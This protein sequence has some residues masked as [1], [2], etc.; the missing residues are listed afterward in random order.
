MPSPACVGPV[1]TVLAGLQADFLAGGAALDD[2]SNRAVLITASTLGTGEASE[3][4][5][6]GAGV[7]VRVEANAARGAWRARPDFHAV[8][9]PLVPLRAGA[10]EAGL[11]G[12]QRELDRIGHQRGVFRR[13]ERD[14]GRTSR[15]H[16][17]GLNKAPIKCGLLC[18]ALGQ[19]P[20]DRDT[21]LVSRRTRSAH[22]VHL[23]TERDHRGP[24]RLGR[25]VPNRSNPSITFCRSATTSEGPAGLK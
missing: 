21:L 4:V 6:R 1:R 22:S 9:A 18:R 14:S 7:R 13:F 2:V 16:D 8:E 19:G 20:A 23:Q 15:K 17:P 12:K 3:G 11:V 24:T 10:G 5:D 25:T